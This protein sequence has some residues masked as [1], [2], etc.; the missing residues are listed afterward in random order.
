LRELVVYIHEPAGHTV[1][2]L[3]HWSALRRLDAMAGGRVQWLFFVA[4]GGA[5]SVPL[6]FFSR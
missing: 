5:P 3:M 1:R 4:G 2:P 6:A